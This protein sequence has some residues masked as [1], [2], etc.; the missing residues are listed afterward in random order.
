MRRTL[1]TLLLAFAVTPGVAYAQASNFEELA[2]RLDLGD[3]AEVGLR[4]G[5]IVSGR[6]VGMTR[7]RAWVTPVVT[8][9]AIGVTATVR[10]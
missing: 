10:W 9:L 5:S 1:G 8:P 7:P 2:L 4:D 3:K 6:V